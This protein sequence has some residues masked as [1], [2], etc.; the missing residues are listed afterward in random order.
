MIMNRNNLPVL[1]LLVFGFLLSAGAGPLRPAPEIACDEPEFFF[2][3]ATNTRVITH[4]FIIS[5]E[6]TFPLFISAVRT[7]CGCVAARLADDTLA[8]GESTTLKV[9]YDL[10][11]RSGHQLRRV[12]VESSD[13]SEPRLVLALTGEAIAPLKIV[14]DHICWGNL[15][16]STPAEKSCEISFSEGDAAYINAVV[17]PVPFLSAELTVLKPRRRYLITV[18]TVP[19]LKLGLLQTPLKVITDHPRLRTIE[20]PMNGRVVGD[21][22]AIPEEIAVKSDDA[23]KVARAILVYSGLKKKF[24]LL[25]VDAPGIDIETHFRP[26][27]IANGYRIDLSNITPSRELNGKKIVIVTDCETNSTLDVPFRALDADEP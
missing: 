10:K 19:P 4:E 24:K 1:C 13:R 6:G 21:I 23:R 8:P 12:I 20:I 26:M 5:N 16:F 2:G 14:P 3:A 17:S 25:R 27:A 15:H 22:Y 9:Q 7:D 11:G 18:R